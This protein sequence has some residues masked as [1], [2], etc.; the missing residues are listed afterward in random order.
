MVVDSVCFGSK[1]DGKAVRGRIFI[2]ENGS[3]IHPA[4]II[5]HGFSINYMKLLHYGE[6]MCNDGICSVM[7]DFCGGGNEG[8]SDGS[9]LEMSVVTEQE[10]LSL[11]LN[12]VM[13]YDYVDKDNI[14]LLG[15]SQ[16][17]FVAAMIGLKRIRDIAGLILWYPAFAIPDYVRDMCRE[18]IPEEY[19]VFGTRIGRIYAEDAMNLHPYDDIHKFKKPVLIIHGQQDDVIPVSYSQRAA[20][21]YPDVE[22]TVIKNAGHGF[23]GDDSVYARKLTSDFIFRKAS[24]ND[25]YNGLSLIQKIMAFFGRGHKG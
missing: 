22:Y 9:T 3:S 24:Q 2:P 15:E 13:S 11:V 25:K 1:A 17:G 19:E 6:E 23:E 20:E 14:F 4:V 18:G 7:F 12:A 5:C 8:S 16:G 10:D 21:C